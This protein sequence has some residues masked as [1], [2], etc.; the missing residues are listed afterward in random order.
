MV[1]ARRKCFHCHAEDHWRRN[2]LKYLESLKTKKSDKPSEGMLIIKSNLTIFFTSS[3]ILNSGSSAHIRTSMQGL[4]ES[5]RLREGNM[6]LRAS[7]GANVATEV[8]GTYPLRLPSSIRLDFKDC[9]YIP[10]ASQ[11]LIFVSVLA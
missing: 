11:N 6:I 8:V 1:E 2:Y 7:N 4:M 5:R 10:V 9:Y 3:C